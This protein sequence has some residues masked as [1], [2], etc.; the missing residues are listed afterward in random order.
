VASFP[1]KP[2]KSAEIVS[3]PVKRVKLEVESFSPLPQVKSGESASLPVTQVFS[4]KAASSFPVKRVNS[5]EIDCSFRME[6]LLDTPRL[7]GT[8]DTGYELLYSVSCVNEE[9]LWTCGRDDVIK[10]FNLQGEI[11]SSVQTKLG[12]VIDIAVTRDGD[13]VYT[14]YINKTVNIVKNNQIHSVITL[15]GWEP[16]YVCCTAAG[17]FLITMRSEDY[18]QSKVARYTG[19]TET[20]SIQV[21]DQGRPLYS[22]GVFR[23]ISENR[24]LD[25]C[26]ADWGARAVVVVNQAAKLRFRYTG[27]AIA[28]PNGRTRHKLFEPVG[29]A[30]DSYGHILIADYRNNCIHF[31]DQDGQFLRYIQ[32][33]CRP[34]DL[35]VDMRDNLFIAERA[36]AKVKKIHYL[37]TQC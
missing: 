3:P 21:D 4:E 19:S 37:Q 13:L 8:I 30:T 7:S 23:Y 27:H 33:L 24:N 31:L 25:I 14:D 36:T 32:S 1:I 29:I 34:W 5:K 35:C 18:R 28:G 6:Q 9:Q 12:N 26:V 16:G 10:L 22:P 2:V 20:Q 11:L 15:Q 17:E